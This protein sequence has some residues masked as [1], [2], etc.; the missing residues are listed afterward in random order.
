MERVLSARLRH[1]QRIIIMS[2]STFYRKED[3]RLFMDEFGYYDLE[4]VDLI[5]W[6][7]RRS[8]QFVPSTLGGKGGYNVSL[9][10]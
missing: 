7:K 10:K 1:A 2:G 9:S 5:F 6:Y 8:R 4:T 3:L